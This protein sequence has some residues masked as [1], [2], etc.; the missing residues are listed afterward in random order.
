[1]TDIKTINHIRSFEFYDFKNYFEL[2]ALN[3]EFKE[4]REVSHS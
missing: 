3:F 1:M 2:R 4:M